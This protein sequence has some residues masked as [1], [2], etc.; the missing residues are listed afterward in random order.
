MRW[1]LQNPSETHS[2]FFLSSSRF[3]PFFVSHP[4]SLF[5]TTSRRSA[6]LHSFALHPLRLVLPSPLS[7]WIKKRTPSVPSAHSISLFLSHGVRGVVWH[8]TLRI[9]SVPGKGNARCQLYIVYSWTRDRQLYVD[10][11]LCGHRSR[12]TQPRLLFAADTSRHLALH[13]NTS[14][15]NKEKRDQR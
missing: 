3:S 2:T 6:A 10:F 7:L 14:R 1:R 11:S 15:K 12:G 8:T 9:R 4:T 5:P 13:A